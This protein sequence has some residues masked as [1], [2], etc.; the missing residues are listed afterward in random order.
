MRDTKSYFASLDV[1]DY[2]F[3]KE[4]EN[5][6]SAWELAGSLGYHLTPSLALS[7]DLSYGSNPQYNDELK[8]LLRLTYSTTL[9]GKGDTK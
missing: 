9:A 1:I 3:R 5:K 8:G 4:I 7:G 6:A 2:L